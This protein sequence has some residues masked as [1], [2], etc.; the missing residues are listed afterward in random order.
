MLGITVFILLSSVSL[1]FVM[2]FT[3]TGAENLGN[4]DVDQVKY[5]KRSTKQNEKI[6]SY[7]TIIFTSNDDFV[8]QI[9]LL[10][11]KNLVLMK[12]R[13]E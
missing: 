2:D 7:G 8:V 9:M 12:L 4:N 6:F 10:V 11:V 5:N 13:Q 1:I 3:I